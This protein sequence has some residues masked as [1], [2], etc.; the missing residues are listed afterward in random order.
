LGRFGFDATKQAASPMTDSTDFIPDD[1]DFEERDDS[2]KIFFRRNNDTSREVTLL[3]KWVPVFVSQ[4]ISKIEE[5]Q[6]V[7]IDKNSLQIGQ[8]FSVQGWNMTKRQ[9]GGRRL[10]LF[11]DL[12][13]HG[14]VVTIPLELSSS[15]VAKLIKDFSI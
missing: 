1:T 9:N 6:V 10:T 13:D 5:G 12:P 2:I 14:R 7:P 15:E 3:K 4:L 11:V 8:S